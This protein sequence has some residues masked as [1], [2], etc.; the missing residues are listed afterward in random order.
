[1]LLLLLDAG[2]TKHC[3]CF[4]SFRFLLAAA[5]S[6]AVAATHSSIYP[7]KGRTNLQLNILYA[8]PSIYNHPFIHPSIQLLR[9]TF[10]QRARFASL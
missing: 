4:S 1:M 9:Q 5:A 10:D 3:V 6:T 8:W 7:H 2:Q